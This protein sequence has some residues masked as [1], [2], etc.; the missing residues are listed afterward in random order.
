MPESLSQGRLYYGDNLEI[1]RHHVPDQ[2]VDLVYLDPPFN[3]A[4]EYAVPLGVRDR[5]RAREEARAFGDVWRWDQRAE[6]SYHSARQMGGRL[7]A[8]LAW[9]DTLL[10]KGDL[11]AYLGMMAIR[12]VEL[13]RVMKPT[14]SLF[15]HCDPTSSHYLKVLLD[16][17]LGPGNFRNE[18]VWRY[19]RWPTR[20]RQFQK[21]HDILLFY[22]K[23]ASPERPFHVLYGYESLAQSTLKTF[24]TKRQ[25][26]D[27]SS[28]H[29]KPGTVDESTP[30]PPLSDVWEVGIIAPISK[31]RHGYPTQKPEA[32]LERVLRA[33]TN[34]GELVLDPFCG[35]GTSL[36]VAER[37]GR[38][39]IGI[40]STALAL[41]AVKRRFLQGFGQR[42]SA[43]GEPSTADQVRRLAER[44]P[45][46]YVWWT[47]SKLGAEPLGEVTPGQ[48]SIEGKV[49]GDGG[50]LVAVRARALN[51]RDVMAFQANLSKARSEH[52]LLVGL[53]MG[54]LKCP[55]RVD[56]AGV[57]VLTPADLLSGRSEDFGRSL[58]QKPP[59]R[60]RSP[61]VERSLRPAQPRL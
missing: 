4:K 3:S 48:D 17:V 49:V 10:G 42:L 35:S 13:G 39:W 57:R 52:G 31:E 8:A 28:G 16:A 20:S 23:S 53:G 19:R 11:L 30:G 1:L 6:E 47:L 32:L 55:E 2:S 24:G 9:L 22:S 34:P 44:A 12:L 5:H 37:L 7:G 54:T 38:Q 33:S 27:F 61:R 59:V 46:E 18:V 40:D 43:I 41:G 45:R 60:R 21:M 51:A 15:L 50:A 25:R 36:A 58:E 26:A 29:R 14:A 56:A